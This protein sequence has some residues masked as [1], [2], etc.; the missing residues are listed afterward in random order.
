MT[1][2]LL[3]PEEV[4]ALLGFKV[5]TVYNWVYL[6]RIPHCKIGGRPRFEEGE[7]REWVRQFAVPIADAAGLSD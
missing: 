4:A 7:I 6:R 5:K 2:K 1:I 3:T